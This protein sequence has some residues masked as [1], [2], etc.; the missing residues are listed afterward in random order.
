MTEKEKRAIRVRGMQPK[1]QQDVYDIWAYTLL[2]EYPEN[3]FWSFVKKDRI[4]CLF[5]QVMFTCYMLS[6]N[7]LYGS[8]LNVLILGLLY[9][10]C[11]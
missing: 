10:M 5:L 11:K 6:Q 9:T 2:I 8:S 3:F 4:R 1:D 7:L